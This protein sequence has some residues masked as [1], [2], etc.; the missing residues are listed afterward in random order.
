M[1]V[2]VIDNT[3]KI[4]AQVRINGSLAVN[5]ALTD[6]LRESRPKTPKADTNFL[7]NNTLKQVT[8]LRGVLKWLTVYA[9]YQERG[10]RADGTRR[11]KNYTTGGTGKSFAENAIKKIDSQRVKYLKDLIR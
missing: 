10:S 3:P 5:R 7:R 9:Q 8:G 2:K 4:L 11:V 6:V 1:S